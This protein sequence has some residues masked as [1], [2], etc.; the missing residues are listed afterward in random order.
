M[1]VA[2]LLSTDGQWRPVSLPLSWRVGQAHEVHLRFDLELE[3]APESVWAL[4]FE[5]LPPDHDLQINGQ[6]VHGQP[7]GAGKALPR[8]VLSHWIDAPPGV[9]HEGHNRVEL[10]VDLYGLPGGISAP[11]IGPAAEVLMSHRVARL[12]RESLP[13]ALNMAVSGLAMFMLLAWWLRRSE[14]LMGLFGGLMLMVS[15][16]NMGYYTEDGVLPTPMGS[17]LYFGAVVLTTTLMASLAIALDAEPR[18]RRQAPWLIRATVFCLVAAGVAALTDQLPKL[19]AIVY[20]VLIL[21]MLA[22]MGRLTRLAFRE[23][24]SAGLQMGAATALIF[25][26]SVHDY[27]YLAAWLSLE[28]FFWLPYLTPVLMSVAA[29]AM[30]RRFVAALAQSE[31]HAHELEH[32]VDERTRDLREAIAAKTRFVAAASHDLR[33]PVASI[34]LLA[35]LLREPLSEQNSRQVMNRLTDAVTAL[36]GLLKGLLDLSRYD[37]QLVAAIPRS[38][39]LQVLFD[40]VATH[41]AEA[42]QQKGLSL[43]LRSANLAVRADPALLEQIVRNLVTNAIQYTNHGGVLLSARRTGSGEVLL[44]VWDTGVGI[45]QAQQR[46]VFEEFVH[47][48]SSAHGAQRGLGL[49]LALVNRAARLMRTTVVLRSIPG[50]GSCFSLRLPAAGVPTAS[51]PAVSLSASGFSGRCFWVIDDDDSVRE[52]LRLRLTGWGACVQTFDSLRA[53]DQALVAGTREPRPDLLITDHH[54]GDG[55]SQAVVARWVRFHPR[56]PVL[57][58]SAETAAAELVRLDALGW[59]R[60]CKPFGTEALRAAVMA[61]LRP[62]KGADPPA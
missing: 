47:L 6:R 24:A 42:A 18:R 30:L 15:L 50:R 56:V 8:S 9:L 36:E 32:R 5:R 28:D 52:S 40:A 53:L 31:R 20:P 29:L 51:K 44:Q 11:R 61:A 25:V 21:C 27:L 57:V 37:A 19:R 41:A 34:G 1:G 10:K 7:V 12:W 54:L 39:R 59:P 58:I 14:R 33:Q 2:E 16:R 22:A 60:L 4:R 62:A 45:P 13:Y 55:D 35:S 26:F 38:V 3:R 46:A 48:Q 23:S 17:L 49:G 43:R